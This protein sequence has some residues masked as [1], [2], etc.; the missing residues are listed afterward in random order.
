VGRK[1][2]LI[3]SAMISTILTITRNTAF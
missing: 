1:L 2:R 3:L